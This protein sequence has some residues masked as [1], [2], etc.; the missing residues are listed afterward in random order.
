MWTSIGD[1]LAC[2]CVTGQDF[3]TAGCQPLGKWCITSHLVVVQSTCLMSLSTAPLMPIL[4]RSAVMFSRWLLICALP[5]TLAA[6]LI[7][8]WIAFGMMI[9]A[10]E[11]Q[12]KG[13]S[14]PYFSSTVVYG[15]MWSKD[16]A[17]SLVVFGALSFLMP[18]LLKQTPSPV[19]L[20]LLT[21][22]NFTISLSDA[23]RC[24]PA[25]PFQAFIEIWWWIIVANFVLKY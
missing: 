5:W 2:V 8:K 22:L 16:E 25:V 12:H 15:G 3:T 23:V 13:S 10:S 20:L 14:A 18:R 1:V 4:T 21:L 7:L 19:S 24:S 17:K 9:L 11:N 6:I